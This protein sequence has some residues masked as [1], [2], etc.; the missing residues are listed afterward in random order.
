[1]APKAKTRERDTSYFRY[2]RRFN[3]A[4][5]LPSG[6]VG[7]RLDPWTRHRPLGPALAMQGFPVDL[8]WAPH[9]SPGSGDQRAA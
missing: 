2:C 5:A 6:V 3:S 8:A 4:L 9:L 7:P 1:M